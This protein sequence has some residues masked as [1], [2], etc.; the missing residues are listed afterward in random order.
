MDAGLSDAE[1]ARRLREEG[2]NEL[3]PATR[4]SLWRLLLSVLT[5]PMFGLLLA[6]GALYA[7][8]GNAQEAWTLMGFVIVVMAIS[9][10]QQQRAER[11]LHALRE[12]SSPQAQVWR[13]GRVC[14]VSS[15]ELVRGDVV[16]LDAGDRVPADV[17]LLAATGVSVDESLLTGESAP[18]FKT[19]TEDA[20]GGLFAGTLLTAG[21]ARGEVV[22]TGA[23][24]ALGRLGAALEG[25]TE[26]ASPVQQETAR[27]V[28]VAAAAGLGLAALLALLYGWQRQDALQGLLAGLTLAMAILPEELPVVLTLFLG[29]GAWRLAREK[30]LVRQMSAVEM[31][32][33]TTV[34]CVDKTGTLT[35]NR[36]AVRRL[37]SPQGEHDL[38]SEGELPLPEAVHETLEYAIL[39]SHR[40]AI[41][42]MERALLEAG[43]REL[44]QT[45]HLHADWTLVE[46]YPLSAELLAMSRVWQS[47]DR[48]E[49]L[50]AAK[51]APEAVIDLCHL[52]AARQSRIVGQVARLADQGWRVLGVARAVFAADCLPPIQHDFDF[53]FVGL[54]ALEDPLRPEVPAAIAE[55]RAAGIRVV[56]MTGDHPSTA[57]SVARQAGLDVAGGVVP[58][59][60]LAALDDMGCQDLVARSGVF[61][62][63]QPEQKLRLVQALQ[64]RGEVVAMTGDGVNDAPALRAAHIGVAMGARGTDVAREAADLVLMQD[65]LTGLVTAVRHGRRVF[66]NLSKAMVFVLAVHVPIIVLT[67]LPVLLGWP[68]LL[69]P[70]HVLCLQLVIDPACSL[71]FEAQPAEPGLMQAP[72]RPR[73]VRLFD[74][75][76]LLRS[77]GQGVGL[78]LLCLG[79]YAGAVAAGETAEAARALCYGVLVGGSVALIYANRHWSVTGWRSGAADGMAWL[80]PGALLL[81]LMAW[82]VPV[83]QTA[84]GFAL[85]G[86]PTMLAGLLLVGL[87]A[88]WFELVK[89]RT[90]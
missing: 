8:L 47:P 52:D 42:P 69:M 45:E 28:R 15:R 53:E 20:A 13:G 59:T 83:L 71:V 57:I 50:I 79:A 2:P 58:G 78:A 62:R 7:L 87:A 86:L 16:L 11:S 10:V 33:A 31:L 44:A 29:L 1:A 24:S 6:C 35:L 65:S 51:G 70:V 27:I 23:R 75:R 61:C 48:R 3:A 9:L 68:M 82:W 90:P 25:G 46:D 43:Q 14:R 54:V 18:V 38:V 63:V 67:F 66:A 85:P 89:R 17:R 49:R 64:A 81:V 19:V 55:C 37:W 4:R 22:A 80:A 84:F 74:R 88:A 56:M 36:M 26:A 73:Q 34:L 41:D 12:L 39:A 60:A 72:P 30:V 77:L 40:Q 32:G 21:S 5:E 76:V